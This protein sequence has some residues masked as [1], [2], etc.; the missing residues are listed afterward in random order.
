MKARARTPL[1]VIALLSFVVVSLVQFFN[2][3]THSAHPKDDAF[4]DSWFEDVDRSSKPSNTLGS[5]LESGRQQVWQQMRRMPVNG[6]VAVRNL[7]SGCTI[8]T[9]VAGDTAGR[10]VNS[11]HAQAGKLTVSGAQSLSSLSLGAQSLVENASGEFLSRAGNISAACSSLSLEAHS[12]AKNASGGVISAAFSI[13]VPSV[14]DK[15]DE[16]VV[17]SDVF[18][19]S[20]RKFVVTTAVMALLI[21]LSLLYICALHV[22]VHHHRW[23]LDRLIREREM[24]PR[25]IPD[26]CST[27]GNLM[28]ILE[29]GF[30]EVPMGGTGDTFGRRSRQHTLESRSRQSDDETPR[31]RVEVPTEFGIMRQEVLGDG[32]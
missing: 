13:K 29:N 21:C 30:G 3:W 2:H 24:Q 19:V 23:H 20:R 15:S 16:I 18:V 9:K 27:P 11:T 1:I 7:R 5:K 17:R 26:Q 25:S 4:L 31:R 6:K 32:W 14:W 8:V 28:Q 22:T 10:L 12:L